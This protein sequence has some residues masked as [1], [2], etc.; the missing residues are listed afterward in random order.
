MPYTI[1]EKELTRARNAGIRFMRVNGRRLE[2]LTKWGKWASHSR[3][4]DAA[5]VEE[6]IEH[7]TRTDPGMVI[8]H[9]TATTKT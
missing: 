5:L 2:E 3:Y 1:T 8:L 7:I 4:A 6:G 9:D